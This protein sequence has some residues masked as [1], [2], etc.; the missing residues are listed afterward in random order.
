LLDWAYG[1]P[2]PRGIE[3]MAKQ[4]TDVP[5]S[6]VDDA[7]EAYIQDAKAAGKVERIADKAR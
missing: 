1:G 4:A 2:V 3:H 7:I 5:E 6:T